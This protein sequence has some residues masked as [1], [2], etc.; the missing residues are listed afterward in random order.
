MN[1][2]TEIIREFQNK[3]ENKLKGK[4]DFYRGFV[5]FLNDT[6]PRTKYNYLNHIITFMNTCGKNVNE[7]NFD[8]FNGYIGRKNN[9][10]FTASY[11]KVVYSAIKKFCEYLYVSGRI[12]KNYMLDIKHTKEKESQ[13]TIEK[14]ENGYLTK[15]ELNKV[16]LLVDDHFNCF[17]RNQAVEYDVRD[18]AMIY[19]FLTTGIRNSA[20][21]SLDVDNIDFEN[22]I[23]TV[24]E[25]GSYVREYNLSENVCNILLQWL[26]YRSIIKRKYNFE[27]NALFISRNKKRFSESAVSNMVKK[28]TN[29]CIK[30]KNITPHKLRA[31]YGT[32]LYNETKDIYFV[33]QCMGH[34][35]PR[36]TEVYI[37]GNKREST[38]RASDIMSKLL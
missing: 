16:L 28:Y 35:S 18:K 31:T 22:R 2:T 10:G 1:G 19:L 25:K 24:T 9:E 37:R 6:S 32:Q 21:R 20:L 8:D 26:Q 12:K 30:N 4:E 5:N 27:T 34:S 3:I 33:Q 11:K 23:M 13:Q 29:Y 14:R 7:L 15:K 36:T 17:K 38:Q